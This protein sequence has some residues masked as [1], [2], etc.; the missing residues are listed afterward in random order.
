MDSCETH[1]VIIRSA[2]FRATHPSIGQATAPHDPE[3][4]ASLITFTSET[5]RSSSSPPNSPLL[6]SHSPPTPPS[7]Q[8]GNSAASDPPSASASDH[9]V[10]IVPV[11]DSST[12]LLF[13]ESPSPSTSPA[14][15]E[16]AHAASLPPYRP[17]SSLAFQWGDKSG[18]DVQTQLHAMHSRRDSPLA[19]QLILRSPGLG[20]KTPHDGSHT[21]NI[22]IC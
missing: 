21:P 7:Q 8:D 20:R 14:P 1:K 17:A 3:T 18:P 12:F 2:G 9:I 13:S 11:A 22:S 5:P 16:P 15:S 19:P 4:N 6:F 10:P